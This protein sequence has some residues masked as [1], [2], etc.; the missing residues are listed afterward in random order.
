MYQ[1]EL[2]RSGKALF[3]IRGTYM[4]VLIAIGILVAYLSGASGP[5]GGAS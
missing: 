3:I 5:S 2:A 1:H 4:Y